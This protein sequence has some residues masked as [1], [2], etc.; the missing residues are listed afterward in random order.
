M[1]GI[2]NPWYWVDNWNEPL[3]IGAGWSDQT[4]CKGD[5]GGPLT[6][7]RGSVVVEVGMAASAQP[8]SCDQPGGFAELSGSQLAWIGSQ[9]P[10]DHHQVGPLRPRP[11]SPGTWTAQYHSAAYPLPSHDGP[12]YWDIACTPSFVPPP[13]P[14]VMQLPPPPPTPAAASADTADSRG[15]RARFV[16]DFLEM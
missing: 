4:V 7:K 1:D 14:T 9:V 2:Y 5:S 6:V 3:M 8:N 13:A 15:N 11:G 12:N 16:P 10:S